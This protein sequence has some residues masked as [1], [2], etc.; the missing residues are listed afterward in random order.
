MFL[1]LN[2]SSASELQT[3]GSYELHSQFY[4][5][6]AAKAPDIRRTSSDLSTTPHAPMRFCSQ[7]RSL[8]HAT[9]TTFLTSVRVS[10]RRR[11][12]RDLGLSLAVVR[13]FLRGIA[14]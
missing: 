1:C 7:Q 12:A 11:A 4:N 2:A 8:L 10:T 13:P 3:A 9:R 6:A 14:V 5:F